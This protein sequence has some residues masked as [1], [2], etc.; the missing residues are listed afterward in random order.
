MEQKEL[1]DLEAKCTQEHYPACTAACPVHVDVR[2]FMAAINKENFKAAYEILQ[3]KLPFPG[4]IA[5]ICDRPCEAVCKRSEAGDALAIGDLERFCVQNY[6]P[7]RQKIKILPKKNKQV[8]VVGGG[9]SGLTAAY[10]LA[11]KGYDIVVFEAKNYLGGRIWTY[12]APAL[13]KKIAAGEFA[14]LEKLGVKLKLSTCVGRDILLPD[15]QRQFDAVYL[16]MGTKSLSNADLQSDPAVFSTRWEGV[17]AG[18]SMIVDEAGYSPVLSVSLGR[19]AAVSIDRYLQGVSLTASRKNEGPYRTRLYTST[20]GVKPL[21]R[22][23]K[24]DA[25]GYSKEEA[26]AEAGRCLQ[27]QCLE[28]VKACTYLAEFGSYPKRY[29]RE[30]YNNE[31][32]VMGMHHA[33]KMINSCN[34]CGLCEAVCPNGFN[35]GEVCQQ[36]RSSMVQRGKM[37]PSAFDFPLRDM[38]FNN[39]EKF[40][41][42]RHQ[43]GTDASTFVFFP[44]CQL[45]ASH[46]R[47]VMQV[48]SYLQ[49][50]LTGGVGIMLRCCGVPA[51]WAGE[52]RLFQSA[53]E[54]IQT[55]WREMGQPQLILAC[56][57]C[58][59]I[60]KTHLPEIKILFLW[61]VFRQ[62]GVPETARR[63]K[64]KKL[65]LHDPCSTRWEKHIHESVR[66]VI[67]QL[68]YEVEELPYNKEKTRCCGY[69]GLMY[70]SNPELCS[71]VIER[72][73]NESTADYLTYCAMCRDFFASRGKRALHL[74]DLIYGEYLDVLAE[75]KGPGYSQR[76]ENRVH[77]K[78]KLLDEFWGEKMKPISDYESIKLYIDD[79]VQDILEQRFILK[80]DI[81]KTIAWAEKTGRKFINPDNGRFLACHKLASVTYWVEYAFKGD[82]IEVYNAYSHRMELG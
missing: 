43:P 50:K 74:L 42:N 27:C 56:P 44:G 82:G 4:I 53:L 71:E 73:I 20:R 11:Q 24:A 12:C 6:S 66:S 8:A 59:K 80:E 75:R 55:K 58:Y 18:G 23:Q 33:N 36:A 46:S 68:G 38:M 35:M 9:L 64:I 26:V 70:S 2:G 19:R 3:K 47:Q 67:K 29:V 49:E 17:F 41:L 52:E 57:T 51:E 32:I 28:C 16:G 61:E 10:D 62:K 7:S 81:Q 78:Y 54:E 76:H 34:L 60:F 31:S 37:P 21:A 79:S 22:V 69:G 72:R 25:E 45:S 39:S 5:R 63:N 48:Y 40:A 13:T 65:A 77:L 14:V 30:I 1:R 15:L